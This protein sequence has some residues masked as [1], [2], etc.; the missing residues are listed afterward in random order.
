MSNAV[1]YIVY[2]LYHQSPAPTKSLRVLKGF[3]KSFSKET[4]LK[5][6]NPVFP[7]LDQKILFLVADTVIQIMVWGTAV[8]EYSTAKVAASSVCPHTQALTC[9]HWLPDTSNVKCVALSL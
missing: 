1:C 6:M 8:L 4:L 2:S 3:E 5:F 7:R 9:T